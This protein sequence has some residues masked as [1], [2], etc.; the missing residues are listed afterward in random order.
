MQW[1]TEHSNASRKHV[2][3]RHFRKLHFRFSGM[4]SERLYTTFQ[5]AISFTD[6][7]S[8]GPVTVE[9]KPEHK[10]SNFWEV[11]GLEQEHVAQQLSFRLTR[12]GSF[13]KKP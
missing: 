8:W 4:T 3:V 1:P 5:V 11:N 7:F 12:V 10:N 6:V 2:T 9:A 13:P